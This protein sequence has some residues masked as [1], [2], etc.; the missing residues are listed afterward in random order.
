[1]ARPGF[2]P[3]AFLPQWQHPAVIDYLLIKIFKFKG[4]EARIL[5]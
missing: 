5:H 4:H 1:M 2:I 3:L